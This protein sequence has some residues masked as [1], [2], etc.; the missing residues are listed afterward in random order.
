MQL[1]RAVAG[2]NSLKGIAA[3]ASSARLLDLHGLAVEKLE[4]P[5]Y[6]ARPLFVHPVLNRS[7]IVKHNVRSG[8]DDRLAPRRFNVT[9]VIFPFDPIDLGLGGQYLFV[10]Q[11][12]FI[13]AFT[14][15]LD[16]SGLTLERDVAVLNTLDRLPTLDPFLVSEILSQQKIDVARCYY[17]VSEDDQREMLG[18]VSA[19]IEALIRVCFGDVT[20]D[21]TRA[22]RLAELLLANQDSPE[23][24]PLRQS[25]RM[26]E[27]EFG[28]A[29]FSWKA[30][31][32]YR[33]RS[34]AV[35]PQL[36]STLKSISAIQPRLCGRD[37]Q[38]LLSNGK[39]LL[40]RAVTTNWREV[41]RR[42]RL[43]DRAFASLTRREN[44]ADFRAFLMNGSNQFIELGD[45]IGRLEQ[46]VSFWDY[47]F[48]SGA[49]SS[50]SAEVIL[51]GLRD[52]LQ[53]LSIGLTVTTVPLA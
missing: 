16:Y 44:A 48:G 17:R 9:K 37:D 33:W 19:E 6:L 31:L 45:N 12:D 25:F 40:E 22:R 4:D 26:D 43:Y 14:R 20:T 10:G 8:E 39:R 32:Y 47:R 34:R 11:R 15:Q 52:L 36:K 46:V 29:M 42:L 27:A 3:T 24:E 21:D 30:F 5:D 38:R 50:R 49:G 7:I 1:L 41:E 51:D 53:S 13:A 18:F 2:V 28:E 35:S 23:L